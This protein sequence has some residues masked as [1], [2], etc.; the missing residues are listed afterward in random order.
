MKHLLR[1]TQV[2][3]STKASLLFLEAGVPVKLR[4]ICTN[5]S[6]SENQPRYVPSSGGKSKSKLDLSPLPPA[7]PRKKFWDRRCWPETWSEC[8]NLPKAFDEQLVKQ[9]SPRRIV[10]SKGHLDICLQRFQAGSLHVRWKLSPRPKTLR[11]KMH[12]IRRQSP[13]VPGL[14]GSH[15][16]LQ[17]RGPIAARSRGNL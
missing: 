9:R 6:K 15:Q 14:Q 7:K 5:I 4:S 13:Y 11:K 1:I 16:G 17:S 8:H 10:Q 2:P 12:R 3:L